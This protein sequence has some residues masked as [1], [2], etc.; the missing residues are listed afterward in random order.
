[1]KL[2][3]ATPLY[4]PE[5]GGPAT[6]AKLLHDELPKRGHTVTIVTF[7]QVRRLP[8]GIRHIAYFGL[9]LWKGWSHDVIL[10]QDVGSVGFPAAL[11]ARLLGKRFLVRVPGDFAWEQSRQRF[12]VTDSLETFQ[13]TK[14]GGRVELYKRIEHFIVRSAAVVMTPSEYF[15]SI[16]SQ[17]TTER[18][19][20]TVYNGIDVPYI[21]SFSKQRYSITDTFSIV[22]SG[23]MVP[24]KGFDALIA[25]LPTHPLWRLTLIGSGPEKEKLIEQASRLSVSEQVQFIDSLPQEKL[26]ETIATHDV[27][28]L[29]SSFESFSYQVVETMALGVPV[30]ATTGCNLEEILT[31]GK[32]GI[33]IPPHNSQALEAALQRLA[34]QSEL[35][36]TLSKAAQIRSNDFSIDR[37][38]DA[39]VKFFQPRTKNRIIF[40][41]TDRNAFDTSSRTHQR[42]VAYGSLA[43]EVIFIIPT[44]RSITLVRVGNVQFI[45]SRSY[46][47]ILSFFDILW[48]TLKYTKRLSI[49]SPQDPGF[50]GCIGYVACKVKRARLYTQLHT[51]IFS[52]WY[53]R[54]MKQRLEKLLARFIIPRSQKVRVVSQQSKKRMI[55]CTVP[56]QVIPVYT[57]SFTVDQEPHELFTFLTVARLE[58]EK[59]IAEMLKVL[60]KVFSIYPESK[61]CIAGSGSQFAKLRR[62]AAELGIGDKVEFLGWVANPTPLYARADV[63]IQ[64]SLYEG[65]GL[66]YMEALWATCPSVSTDVG[67]VNEIINQ[68]VNGY[69]CPVKD[70]AC[71]YERIMALRA[72]GE[73]LANMRSSLKQNPIPNRYRSFDSYLDELNSFYV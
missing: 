62:L 51:D 60:A 58:P 31:D 27:F 43:D 3:L 56:I 13:H 8:P 22:S 48:L 42:L 16:V 5:I 19:P 65:Y 71:M 47:R 57:D 53:G 55:W 50:L 72:D 30:I 9:C 4:P 12:G 23:R 11:A 37:T 38:I 61:Y 54:T 39:L 69:V 45:P 73:M 59:N 67:V 18:K 63:Y 32:N 10:A 15:T 29:N 46:H 40:L 1:M 28:V 24:W 34:T 64:N 44:D 7:S 20:V 36:I 49:V 6:Y 41:G 2:L 26:F 35:R 70:S 66:S 14:Y 25:L 17:W 21:Q 33:L 52:P 68:G